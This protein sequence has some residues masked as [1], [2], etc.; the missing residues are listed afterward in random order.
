MLSSTDT[1]TRIP[2]VRFLRSRR[3]AGGIGALALVGLGVAH[4]ATNAVGFATDPDASWPLFLIFGVGVSILLGA[5][6]VVA[7]RFSRHGGGRI[8][9]VAIAVVGFLCCL[10]AINVLRVHPEIVLS[11]AGPGPWTLVGGPALLTAAILPLRRKDDRVR[12]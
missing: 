12:S 8:R 6:A 2:A 4:T 5:I 1:S 7:W 10:M 9:R 11:P 3:A